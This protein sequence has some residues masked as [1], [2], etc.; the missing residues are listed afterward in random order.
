MVTS[1]T[2]AGFQDPITN[3]TILLT[4]FPASAYDQFD[5]AMVPDAMKKQGI[6]VER[7]TPIDLADGKGFVLS[8]RETA[9]NHHF[10]KWLLVAAVGD[11]T[12]VV[13]FQVQEQDSTYSE[14]I[15]RAAFATLTVRARVPDAEQLALIP[16]KIGELAGF[17]IEDVVPGRGIVLVD[18]PVDDT[19]GV[20]N[21]TAKARMFIA[22]MPGGPAEASDRDSFAR[23]S[24]GQIGGIRDTQLQDGGPLR[25]NGQPGYQI[26]AKGK[27]AGTGTEVMVVQW[28]RFGAGGY[29]RMI[30]IARAD[31]WPEMFGRLRT[32]RDS[33]N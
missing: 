20:A 1:R 19:P 7:R 11:L 27:D 29:L 18:L 23:V 24:F 17:R 3:A 22:A 5:K 30:G 25:I 13:H 4:T 10:R 15:V 9:D 16:F 33:V 26:L 21:A 14:E 6:V 8:G 28:L 12:A 31:A 32:V 2:F